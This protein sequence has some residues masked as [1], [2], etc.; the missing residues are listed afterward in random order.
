MGA[1]K[2]TIRINQGW[3]PRKLR[4]STPTRHKIHCLVLGSRPVLILKT[5]WLKGRPKPYEEGPCNPMPHLIRSNSLHLPPNGLTF[6]RITCTGDKVWFSLVL[7]DAVSQWPPWAVN[8]VLAQDWLTVSPRGPWAHRD[9]ISLIPQ[10]IIQR[11]RVDSWQNSDIGS[12]L[13]GKTSHRR[14]GQLEV[15]KPYLSSQ[16]PIPSPDSKSK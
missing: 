9:V 4:A 15:F 14:E 11:N 7:G 13:W 12:L 2:D 5:H 8:G 16:F 3:M 6:T 10:S 1:D